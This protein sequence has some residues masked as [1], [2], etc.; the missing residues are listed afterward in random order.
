MYEAKFLYLNLCL[1]NTLG[2]A[3]NAI[4]RNN[5][6]MSNIDNP[7]HV[8]YLIIAFTNEDIIM[9]VSLTPELENL[10]KGQVE[11]GLYNSSSEV[12]REA[13]RLW[14]EQQQY[15]KKMELL[16]AKL[17]LAEKSPLLDEFSMTDLIK[18]LDDE[19]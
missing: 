16:R 19:N 4:A 9:H 2:F 1:G 14:N 3:F 11:S 7:S 15:K 18:D 10:V 12:V 13:L 8:L 6:I 17:E 5:S